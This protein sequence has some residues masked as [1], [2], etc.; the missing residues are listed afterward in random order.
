MVYP[1]FVFCGIAYFKKVYQ[2]ESANTDQFDLCYRYLRIK[3]RMH[4]MLA[5]QMIHGLRASTG[6]I[7]I[8]TPHDRM[9]KQK[10]NKIRKKKLKNID[11]NGN[12]HAP[13][14]YIP[15]DHNFS[16]TLPLC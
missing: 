9:H 15:R 11:K 16:V 5:A 12:I 1:I 2:I 4:H 8:C 7:K 10:Q 13:N 3:P 6:H 14:K